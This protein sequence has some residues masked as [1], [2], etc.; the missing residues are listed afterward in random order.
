MSS[1]WIF[2]SQIR[3]LIEIVRR[4]R[5]AENTPHKPNLESDDTSLFVKLVNLSSVISLAIKWRSAR[6]WMYLTI[7]WHEVIKDKEH[8]A[9]WF[10]NFTHRIWVLFHKVSLT[11]TS[12][13][14][15]IKTWV[16][17]YMFHFTASIIYRPAHIILQLLLIFMNFSGMMYLTKMYNF[18]FLK[19]Q[20]YRPRGKINI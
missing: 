3:W 8:I 1:L 14:K 13:F 18:K 7:K 20:C 5:W 16:M 17:F 12:S 2:F 19:D 15:N 6:S 4:E 10:S 9:A 11:L